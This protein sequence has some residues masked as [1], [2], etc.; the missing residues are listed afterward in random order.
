MSPVVITW[1]GLLG[2][3]LMAVFTGF[4]FGMLAMWRPGPEPEPEPGP[5]FPLVMPAPA[6]P[7]PLELQGRWGPL[8]YDAVRETV[9]LSALSRAYPGRRAAGG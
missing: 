9:P 1:P 3:A 8:E 5:P 7:P 2:L 6:P 4:G